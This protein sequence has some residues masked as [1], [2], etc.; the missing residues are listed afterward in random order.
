MDSED[1]LKAIFLICHTAFFMAVIISCLVLACTLTNYSKQ[2]SKHDCN[3]L[4][5]T[6]VEQSDR[7]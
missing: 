1:K 4:T 3:N 6:T 5:T 2:D 7:T